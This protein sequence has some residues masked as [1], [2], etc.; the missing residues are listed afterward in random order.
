MNEASKANDTAPTECVL[1]ENAPTTQLQIRL[2]DGTR[3]VARFNEV[4]FVWMIFVFVL[5]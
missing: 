5:F 1:D 4:F 3:L 2:A